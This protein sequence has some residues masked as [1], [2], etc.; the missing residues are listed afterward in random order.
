MY[1]DL[2]SGGD[3]VIHFKYSGIINI[4]Y[5]TC[6]YGVG[7]PILFPIAALNFINQYICERIVIAYFMKQPPALD[8]KLTKNAL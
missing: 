1:R 2:Y 7:M 8:D 3:Y 4:V 5:I 6:M